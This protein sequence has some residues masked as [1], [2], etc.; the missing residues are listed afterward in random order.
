MVILYLIRMKSSF[1][2]KN[3]NQ[4]NIML[5]F[6]GPMK[7]NSRQKLYGKLDLEAL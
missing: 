3:E 4:Y 5:L 6:I 1:S 2:I 7:G